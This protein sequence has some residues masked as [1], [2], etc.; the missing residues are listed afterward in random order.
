MFN[1]GVVSRG[2]RHFRPVPLNKAYVGCHSVLNPFGVACSVFNTGVVSRGGRHFRPVPLNTVRRLP[3]GFKSLRGGIF[4]VQYRRRL[5]RRE[6]FSSGTVEYGVR[7]LPLG[8]KSP[9]GWR[10]PPAPTAPGVSEDASFSRD[11]LSVDS[12][13]AGGHHHLL[14]AYCIFNTGV[15]SRGGRH[16][17]PI[18]LNTAYVGCLLWLCLV[19]SFVRKAREISRIRGCLFPLRRLAFFETRSVPIG[20]P[21]L[22]SSIRVVTAVPAFRGERL[23]DEQSSCAVLR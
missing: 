17:R 22:L 15:V 3:I 23:I 13:V 4:H 20:F 8:F 5:P 14:G 21:K 18:P 19:F 10:C 1:T 7:L 2:G 16:F 12:V 9:A 11:R 6:T